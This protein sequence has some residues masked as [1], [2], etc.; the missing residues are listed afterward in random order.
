MAL[1][2]GHPKL[3][4][5]F[6]LFF[7]PVLVAEVVKF[8][9]PKMVEMHNYVPANSTQQKLS[10]WAHLNRSVRGMG[11]VEFQSTIVVVAILVS[12]KKSPYMGRGHFNTTPSA[13]F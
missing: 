7:H 10:N 12:T 9:F 13:P 5:M 1:L 11:R 2:V 6:L 3:P 8:Y 4:H